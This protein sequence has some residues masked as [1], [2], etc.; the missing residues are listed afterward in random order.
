MVEL[1]NWVKQL[2]EFNFTADIVASVVRWRVEN[3]GFA[4]VE[5]VFEPVE[6]AK[7]ISLLGPVN[8]A[9]R[10][11]LLAL[12]EIAALAGSTKLLKL[13]QPHLGETA[14]PVRGIYFDKTPEANWSVTWHQDLLI[15]VRERI[16]T[17]GFGPWS[18]KAHIP[19]V[20]PPVDVLKQMLTVR[21]HL[22]DTNEANG[23]LRVLAGSHK[24]EVLSS[25]AADEVCGHGNGVLCSI[26]AGGVLLMRPLLLHSSRKS[27]NGRHRRVLHIEYA[28]CALPNGLEWAA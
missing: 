22:D 6:C 27:S 9:G 26:A 5:N 28:G 20:Q 2:N 11:N 14:K 3:D 15:P 13:V 21:L 1:V 12:P 24:A 7:L 23:A 4:L 8:G 10:R 25:E 17:P 19:H 16:D 18:V